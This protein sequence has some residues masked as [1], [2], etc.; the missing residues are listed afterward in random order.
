MSLRKLVAA[1][2]AVTAVLAL[3]I[4]VAGAS[5][6]TTKSALSTPTIC[7]LLKSQLKLATSS[8]NTVLAGL[9][10]RV[11]VLQHC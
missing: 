2:A 9:L 5:A 10:S 7:V 4:P 8:G 1:L 11:L 6:A 3:T